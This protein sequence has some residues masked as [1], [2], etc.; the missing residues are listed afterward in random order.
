MPKPKRTDTHTGGATSN[1]AVRKDKTA[2]T[3][4]PTGNRAERRAAVRATR[5]KK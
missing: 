1:Y 4:N 2:V 3:P 5:K